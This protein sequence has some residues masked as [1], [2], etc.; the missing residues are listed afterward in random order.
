MLDLRSGRKDGLL[1]APPLEDFQ[2]G[3]V[4]CEAGTIATAGA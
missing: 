4:P 2:S 3:K 1:D